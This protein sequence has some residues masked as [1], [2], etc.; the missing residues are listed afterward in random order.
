MKLTVCD[1]S[2]HV[3]PHLPMVVSTDTT[4]PSR[5]YLSL[6]TFYISNFKWD[7][8]FL[9]HF[10]SSR[11]C[12]ILFLFVASLSRA[13]DG[14]P[15]QIS[16]RS[17]GLSNIPRSL[18]FRGT[19]EVNTYPHPLGYD[20][21]LRYDIHLSF[22]LEHSSQPTPRTQL[23]SH[24]PFPEA[25]YPPC[26]SRPP[27]SLFAEYTIFVHSGRIEAISGAVSI[28]CLS[29]CNPIRKRVAQFESLEASQVINSWS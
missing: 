2:R 17:H 22:N 1:I 14:A 13:N 26:N 4:M 12:R 11:L 24:L 3:V 27:K 23:K 10:L 21:L 5:L 25:W 19:R 20:G 28:A 16:N 29:A 7:P 15:E 6:P 9:L 8:R 18:Q